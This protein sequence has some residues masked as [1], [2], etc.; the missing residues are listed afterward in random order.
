MQGV[1]LTGLWV[2]AARAVETER[3][4]ALFRDPF[5]RRLAGEEGFEVLRALDAIATTRPPGIEVRT[6]F[7][8][9]ELMSAVGDELRQVVVLAAGMDA[10]AYRLEWPAGTVFFEIDQS[11]VLDAKARLLDGALPRCDRRTVGVDLRQDWPAALQCAGFDASLPTVWLAEGLLPY[12]HERE[13][14]ALVARVTELACS[15]SLFLFDMNGRS[16]FESPLKYIVDFVA[17]LGAPWHFGTDQPEALLD[18]LRWDVQGTEL[19]VVGHRLGR[20]PSPT[21]G[22]GTAGVPQS[23]VVRAMRRH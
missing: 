7:F 10:S 1:A 9:D 17:A 16:V 4:D 23:F 15:R 20:W 5:A 11:F 2:A 18:P 22:R 6:R 19:S 3:E 8:D 12:L 13:V 21:V 14:N